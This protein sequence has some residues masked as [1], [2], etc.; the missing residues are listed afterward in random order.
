MDA[1]PRYHLHETSSTDLSKLKVFEA[2]N[3]QKPDGSNVNNIF[4]QHTSRKDPQD[5]RTRPLVEM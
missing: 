3:R 1:G 2:V 5:V 4:N